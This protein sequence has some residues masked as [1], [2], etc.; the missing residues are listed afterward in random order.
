MRTSGDGARRRQRELNGESPNEGLVFV[1]EREALRAKKR[2][3]GRGATGARKVE[4]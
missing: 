1:R 2:R 3:N 4:T